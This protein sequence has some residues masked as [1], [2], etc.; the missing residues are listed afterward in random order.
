[1]S[2][3]WYC[4]HFCRLCTAVVYRS[5]APRDWCQSFRLARNCGTNGTR[6]GTGYAGRYGSNPKE[7]YGA[8][9]PSICQSCYEVSEDVAFYFMEQFPQA[10]EEL[11]MPGAPGKYQLN[12]WK[13]N[14][15]VLLEA[16]IQIEHLAVTN[17]CTCCNPKMLFSHRASKGSGAILERL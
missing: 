6:D 9:G 3:I 13:A 2:Q 12:L 10:G 15:L 5:S 1:M 4:Q 7:L 8:V 16:G 14:E 17:I 11:C